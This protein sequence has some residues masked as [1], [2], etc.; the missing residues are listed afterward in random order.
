LA[1]RRFDVSMLT[2]GQAGLRRT[3]V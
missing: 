3:W 1:P 2:N